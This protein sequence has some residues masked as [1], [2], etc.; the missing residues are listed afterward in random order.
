MSH[1]SP[2]ATVYDSPQLPLP[3]GVAGVAGA[4]GVVGSLGV[5]PLLQL[6]GVHEH[7]KKSANTE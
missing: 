6:I 7:C 4:A 3:D 5:E 1:V 2:E